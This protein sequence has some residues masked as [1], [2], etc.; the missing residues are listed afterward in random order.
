MAPAW[1]IVLT[2][3]AEKN[4]LEL[5]RKIYVRVRR[6]LEWLESNFDQ[7][8]PLPLEREWRGFFKLRVGDYRIIY[9]IFWEE[10][11][12]MVACIGHRSEVYEI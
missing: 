5:D 1:K 3:D 8:V 2:K 10:R 6:K 4:L 12:L 11:L 7:V 9:K